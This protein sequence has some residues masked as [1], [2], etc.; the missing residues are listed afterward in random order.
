MTD[1]FLQKQKRP[2]PIET[3]EDE[4]QSDDAGYL[5]EQERCQRP[6]KRIFSQSSSSREEK[7]NAV[8]R[9]AALE[10]DKW[11]EDVQA[12]ELTCAGCKKKVKLRKD[13]SYA[14][15]PW[16]N[17]KETCKNVKGKVSVSIDAS[18]KAYFCVGQRNPPILQSTCSQSY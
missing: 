9:K 1:S 14:P 12:H 2:L 5:T 4:P 7:T 3:D 11:T 18:T 6:K 8:T 16:N 13:V 15:K 10:A 17:H